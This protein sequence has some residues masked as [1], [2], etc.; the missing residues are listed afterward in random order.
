[1]NKF[2]RLKNLST[3]V[4]LNIHALMIVKK[5]GEGECSEGGS[6]VACEVKGKEDGGRR[7]VGRGGKGRKDPLA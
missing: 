7:E 1:M 5:R 2:L 4:L 3:T 6:K